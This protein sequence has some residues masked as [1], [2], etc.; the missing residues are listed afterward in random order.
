[1]FLSIKSIMAERIEI[2]KLRN[3]AIQLCSVGIYARGRAWLKRCLLTR[4]HAWLGAIHSVRGH[5]ASGFL[6]WRRKIP[7]FLMFLLSALATCRIHFHRTI[8]FE[9]CWRAMT[10]THTATPPLSL[11]LSH[12]HTH[13]HTIDMFSVRE[14]LKK[15]FTFDFLS[16]ILKR[17]VD[18]FARPQFNKLASLFAQNFEFFSLFYFVC[19]WYINAASQNS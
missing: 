15:F 19:L 13:T 7:F 9:H 18:Q 4:C 3:P 14:T 1:M 6:S 16:H 17:K 8:G 11:S 10:A 12:T 5:T 2:C